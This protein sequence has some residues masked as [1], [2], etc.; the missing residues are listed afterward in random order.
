MT[1]EKLIFIIVCAFIYVLCASVYA[2]HTPPLSKRLFSASII[3]MLSG[4]LSLGSV[5]LVGLLGTPLLKINFCTVF[6]AATCSV[7]GV[8]SMLFLNII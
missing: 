1:L 4:L 6:A 7:P 3:S 2:K 8:I 5:Y